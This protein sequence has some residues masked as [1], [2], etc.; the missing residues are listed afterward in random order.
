[1][2]EGVVDVLE[3]VEVEEHQRAA[4]IVAFEQ[5]DLLTQAIHQQ[6]A[7]GQ[8]GQRVVVSQVTNLRFGI[9]QQADVPRGQQ[10]AGGFVEGDRLHRDFDGQ[11]LTALVAREH[12][13]VMDPALGVQFGQQ[14]RPLFFFGPNPDLVHRAAH[15]FLGAVTGQAAKP[16]VDLQIEAT[17][18]LGDGDGIRAGVERLGELLFAGLECR[19]RAL[20]L[21]DVAQCGDDAG[22]LANA[23]LATGNH[24]GQ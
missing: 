24:A 14:T 23:D 9:F 17:V 7:V 18:A 1:M 2:T 21:G 8:V 16:I 4:Q 12:F 10:Q 19:F 13:P 3:V 11:Q 20:L 5:G 22:L 6:C 15:H